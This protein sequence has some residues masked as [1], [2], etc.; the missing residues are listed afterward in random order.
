MREALY[1]I[2]GICCESHPIRKLYLLLKV[3]NATACD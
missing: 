1:R 2:I 3:I